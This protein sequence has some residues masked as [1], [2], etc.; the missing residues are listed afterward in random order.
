MGAT[1]ASGP[2]LSFAK[3]GLSGLEEERRRPAA[4]AVP[5][6]GKRRY[7]RGGGKNGAD[8]SAGRVEDDRRR[9]EVMKGVGQLAADRAACRRIRRR[10]RMGRLPVP[11]LIDD[12]GARSG[13]GR[14]MLVR[15]GD[16]ALPGKGQQ[17]REQDEPPRRTSHPGQ[18]R[19]PP[20]ARPSHE[21]AAGNGRGASPGLARLRALHLYG[22]SIMHPAPLAL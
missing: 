2:R 19:A 22:P 18:V 9:R 1:G 11:V 4:P 10:A 21:A 17:G 14:V 7:A 12:D 3:F 8:D 15:R 6:P 16:D 5:A 20:P 13:F